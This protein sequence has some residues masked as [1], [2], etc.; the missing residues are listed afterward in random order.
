MSEAPGGGRHPDISKA[1]ES[2]ARHED[3]VKLLAEQ[4]ARADVSLR[5]LEARAGKL[6]GARLPRTTCADMLAGRRF[7]KKAVM[8]AFLR[9]CHVPDLQLPAWERAWER[10]RVHQLPAT[11]YQ[12]PA[13]GHQLQAAGHQFPPPGFQLPA[14]GP[15]SEPVPPAPAD[16]TRRWRRVALFAGAA[17]FVTLGVVVVLVWR[18]EPQEIRALDT[19]ADQSQI[20][21]DDGRAF[22][23]G[24]SSRFTVTVDP[25]HTGVRLTRRLDAAVGLQ[26]AVITVDGV[27]AAEWRP[28]VED[29]VYKWRDQVVAI[30]QRLTAGR[31]SLTVVNTC[32]SSSGFNEFLYVVEHQVDG[33]WSVADTVDVGRG[34]AVSEVSHDYRVVGEDWAGTQTF[35]YPPRAE[36]R[37]VR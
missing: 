4:F 11:G 21:T 20:V 25:A 1:L 3:L 19:I 23:R 28:L 15:V 17:A 36:D 24:G 30:P 26:H 12:L 7:P 27:K 13:A 9:G 2:V 33:V 14:A 22:P 6:D 31:G 18:P 16:E 29:G 10:V 8:V 32:V 34:H 5:E 35:A 37:S